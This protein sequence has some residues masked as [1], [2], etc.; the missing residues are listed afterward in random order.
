[1]KAIKRKISLILAGLM[2]AGATATMPVK[3]EG[4]AVEKPSINWNFSD[5]ERVQVGDKE[6]VFVTSDYEGDV[7]YL[8]W[9]RD[10][11]GNWKAGEYSEAV[12]AKI[13]YFLQTGGELKEGENV[14]SIW[15]KRAGA[16]NEDL[17]KYKEVDA[18][19]GR[20]EG[21][22]SYHFY[23]ITPNETVDLNADGD[24]EFTQ[25]G[26][27][28][29]VKG[30]KGMPEGTEYVAF[31]WDP[32]GNEWFNK[33][34]EALTD[35]D[36]EAWTAEELTV[37]L[38]EGKKLLLDVW[39]K[40]PGAE[41]RQNYK[42]TIVEAKEVAGTEVSFTTELDTTP[43]FGANMTVATESAEVATYRIFKDGAEITSEAAKVNEATLVFPK[44]AAGDDIVVKFFDAN[45]ALV[46]EAATTVGGEGSFSIEEKEV[47]EYAVEAVLDT[48]PMFGA[49]ITVSNEDSDVATYRVFKDGEEITSEAAK[50][51]EATLV[52]PKPAV[53]DTIK[54][55]LFDANDA[56]LSEVETTIK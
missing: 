33:D 18:E 10:E 8:I 46:G 40:A 22:D 1:M 29:T 49:N 20:M 12:P 25:N 7:Q 37:K 28:L 45:N 5:H 41:K 32:V 19:T 50:I 26:S 36:K 6:G 9:M 38:V 52:F 42:L 54:V 31:A 34:G 55:Q 17:T 24:I 3:A 14:I 51:N 23:K 13:P 56:L 15:V 11:E 27:E 21:Y 16:A 47:K 4:T 53:G 35:A 2:V 30:I 44:P 43:M 39:A 48:T